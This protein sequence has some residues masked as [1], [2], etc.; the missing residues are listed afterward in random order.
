VH[1]RPSMTMPHKIK[2]LFVCGR[3]NRRSPTAEKIFKN[4]RRISVRSAGVADTSKRK[5]TEADLVWA[6]LVLV[7]ERKY[8]SRIRDAF[9][10][11]ESLPPM[12]SL[13]IS[14]EYI[15]MQAELIENLRAA[16]TD[17]LEELE[18]EKDS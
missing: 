18:L 13:D 7:M 15:F 3:N 8:A 4:D 14:D 11:L 9:R 16:V 17:V 5:I 1:N 6:D 2:V 10:H 12:E